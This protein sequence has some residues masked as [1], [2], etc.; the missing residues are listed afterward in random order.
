MIVSA[1][2]PLMKHNDG[3]LPWPMWGVNIVNF[4]RPE[5]VVANDAGYLQIQGVVATDSFDKLMK[6]DYVSLEGGNKYVRSEPTTREDLRARDTEI[7]KRVQSLV[8]KG[9]S[10]SRSHVGGDA[11]SPSAPQKEGSVNDA[12]QDLTQHPADFTSQ[13]NK[14]APNL[15]GAPQSKRK[16]GAS[17][18]LEE[19]E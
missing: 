1:V 15:S 10:D 13:Q 6:S 19:P 8:G 12:A 9:R 5:M 4:I 14:T 2:N 18:R 11:E 17:K 3:A 7:Q 16:P